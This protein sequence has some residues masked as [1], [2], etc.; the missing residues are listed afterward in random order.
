MLAGT[1]CSCATPTI[2]SPVLSTERR[3]RFL[4][5]LHERVEKFALSLHPD[6]TRLIEF[7]R[8]AAERRARRGLGKPETFNFLGFTHI[9][10][11]SRAGYF[12]LKRKTRRDRMRATL[13]AI[14]GELW[15][16]L[17][18]PIREQGQWL[19]QWYA[20]TLRITRFRPITGVLC[21]SAPCHRP[22]EA[23]AS[24]AQPTGLHDVATD[25]STRGRV[26]AS[27]LHHPPLAA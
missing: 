6:K 24:A 4:A 11:V 16:R 18:E 20:A 26:P 10:G 25:R 27:R 21:L 17:H 3:Q 7:G 19:G 15:L 2:L 13:R 12:L 22:M 14:K 23:F 8:F 1:S 9:C 5:D